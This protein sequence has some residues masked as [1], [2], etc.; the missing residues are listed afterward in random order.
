MHINVFSGRSIAL[1][2]RR[3]ETLELSV[4]N[5]RHCFSAPMIL[6]LQF[7]INKNLVRMFLCEHLFVPS[8]RLL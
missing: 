5:R 3:Q 8:P 4:S 1:N 7:L 2:S 6:I